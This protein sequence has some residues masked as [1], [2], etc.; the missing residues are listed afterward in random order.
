VAKTAIDEMLLEQ[1][2]SRQKVVGGKKWFYL[3][4]VFALSWH[5][6]KAKTKFD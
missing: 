5:P 1:K 6:N 4:F 3:I 2:L